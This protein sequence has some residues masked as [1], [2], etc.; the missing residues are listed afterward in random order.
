MPFRN[1]R[2]FYFERCFCFYGKMDQFLPNFNFKI[3]IY[4]TG[5]YSPP[6]I[7]I[8]VYKPIQLFMGSFAAEN[9]RFKC[10]QTL[11]MINF[12]PNF[13]L[14]WFYSC[15][16]WTRVGRRG[17]CRDKNKA[18]LKLPRKLHQKLPKSAN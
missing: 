4:S 16:K 2:L 6:V 11:K 15:R 1:R 14:F 3:G 9:R 18:K 17:A 7:K 10:T 8:E 5:F 12:G 13:A